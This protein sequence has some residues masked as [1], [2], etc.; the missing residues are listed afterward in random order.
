MKSWLQD[1]DA[2]MYSTH[3]EGNFFVAERLIETL[4]NKIYK[5]MTSVSNNVYIDNLTETNTTIHVI[6]Q[7]KCTYSE[8]NEDNNKESPKFEV[9]DHVKTMKYKKKVPLQIDLKTFLW[10]KKSK[11][12]CRGHMLLLILMVKS[13]WNSIQKRIAKDK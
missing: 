8:F 7:W 6:A 11:S 9:G 2:E 4:K 12:L 3:I 5:Y 13:C 1:N 10:L